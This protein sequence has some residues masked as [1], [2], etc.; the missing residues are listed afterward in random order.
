MYDVDEEGGIV[1][2]GSR[3]REDESF[4]PG[5]T[6]V[7]FLVDFSG[8]LVIWVNPNDDVGP[9]RTVAPVHVFEV[10]GG[11]EGYFYFM[12]ICHDISGSVLESNRQGDDG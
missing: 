4:V 11:G 10:R 6:G 9:D 3:E 2:D 12:R 5:R 8:K 7:T 1:V